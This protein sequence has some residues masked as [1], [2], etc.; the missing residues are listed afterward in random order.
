MN[1]V[2]IPLFDAL[3]PRNGSHYVE[4]VEPSEEGGNLMANLIIDRMKHTL[5]GY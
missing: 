3:D 2:A 4:R 1:V 5:R